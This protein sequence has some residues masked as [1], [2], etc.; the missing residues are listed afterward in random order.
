MGGPL[1]R[2]FTGGELNT[3]PGLDTPTLLGVFDTA[4]YLHDGSAQSLDDV[5]GRLGS[6]AAAYDD[7]FTPNFSKSK[8]DLDVPAFLRRQMD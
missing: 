5:R 1:P 8:D 7:G 2:W 4:P 3:L 6:V